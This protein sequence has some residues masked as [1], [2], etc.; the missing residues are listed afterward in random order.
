ME[1]S[2]LEI[3]KK[4]EENYRVL[5]DNHYQSYKIYLDLRIKS[6]VLINKLEGKEFLNKCFSCEMKIFNCFTCE[7]TKKAKELEKSGV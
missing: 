1:K 2:K 5:A 3:L 6:R 4:K 7:V